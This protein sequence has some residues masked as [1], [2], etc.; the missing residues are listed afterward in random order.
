MPYALCAHLETLRGLTHDD[1][2]WDA[3]SPFQKVGGFD[4]LEPEAAPWPSAVPRGR[5]NQFLA[6]PISNGS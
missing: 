3:N 4:Q 1:L 5:L 6:W 2:K